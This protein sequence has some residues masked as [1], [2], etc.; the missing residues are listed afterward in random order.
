MNRLRDETIQAHV[1]NLF[2]SVKG[3]LLVAEKLRSRE[4]ARISMV[5]L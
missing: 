4:L 5:W 2:T 1:I 3:G